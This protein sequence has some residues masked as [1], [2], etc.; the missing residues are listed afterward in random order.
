MGRNISFLILMCCIIL[1]FI[2]KPW[3]IMSVHPYTQNIF[4]SKNP[5]SFVLS[6]ANITFVLLL[7]TSSIL[8]RF[9]CTLKSKCES[10]LVEWW[11]G[12]GKTKATLKAMKTN[13]TNRFS[14]FIRFTVFGSVFCF[15][16]FG[17]QLG[18]RFSFPAKLIEL[19]NRSKVKQATQE[20]TTAQHPSKKKKP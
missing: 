20:P 7:I 10:V 16:K 19:E 12:M 1:L 6:S 14:S 11:V 8:L 17:V 4:Y 13:W 9:H 15:A 3:E 2:S 5:P 18:L